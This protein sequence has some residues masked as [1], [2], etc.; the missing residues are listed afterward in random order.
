MRPHPSTNFRRT[1]SLAVLLRAVVIVIAFAAGIVKG[2]AFVIVSGVRPPSQLF[3][4]VTLL[5]RELTSV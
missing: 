5:R 4:T 3:T 2:H 1:T